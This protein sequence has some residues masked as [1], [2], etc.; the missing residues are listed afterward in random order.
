MALKLVEQVI[1]DIKTELSTNM[2]AKLIA[3]NAEY[4]DGITLVNFKAYYIAEQAAVAEYPA[5]FILADTTA[6]ENE[7]SGWMNSAHALTIV[8]LI[9]DQNSETLRKRLFRYIRACIELLI[10][11]RTTLGMV[12]NFDNIRFSP[13]YGAQ[14]T[15][16]SDA[17]LIVKVKKYETF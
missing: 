11:A 9:T 16:I 17:S 4:N 7:G 6:I 15:F 1:S 5:M 8:C 13:M 2:A 14:D 12:I 10:T 3:L